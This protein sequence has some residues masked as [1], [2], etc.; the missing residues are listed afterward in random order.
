MGCST[1]MQTKRTSS[2]QQDFSLSIC[3]A[4]KTMI[5]ST[6]SKI[7]EN[8]VTV[9]KKT[10]LRLLEAKPEL[11]DK[12]PGKLD[13]EKLKTTRILFG[14]NKILM[15]SIENAVASVDDNESFRS[16]LVELGRRHQA[17]HL[18]FMATLKELFEENWTT[19]AFEAWSSLVTFMFEAMKIGL[20]DT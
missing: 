19:Q 14:H 17:M 6:W 4:H 10:F 2:K 3:D 15:T 11:Q 7:N 18:A 13:I 12:F 9:G 16:Y 8:R 20:R 5:K 1:S